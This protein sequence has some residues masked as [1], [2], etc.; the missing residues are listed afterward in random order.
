MKGIRQPARNVCHK[1]QIFTCVWPAVNLAVTL[2]NVSVGVETIS[3][4]QIS[5]KTWVSRHKA[6]QD[7]GSGSH[8]TRTLLTCLG[9]T[10]IKTHYFFYCIYLISQTKDPQVSD[11]TVIHT[12]TVLRP[13]FWD[14]P[15][16]PVQEENFWTL[17]C[18]GRLLEAD[19]LIIR[20]NATPS[21]LTSAHLHHPPI[22]C[23]GRMPFLPPNQ[24]CQSTVI[25]VIQCS[26]KCLL[27]LA[28]ISW[29]NKLSLIRA[30]CGQANNPLLTKRTFNRS[31]YCRWAKGA[32]RMH[33]VSIQLW[34]T[35]QHETAKTTYWSSIQSQDKT[36]VL[37]SSQVRDM[38]NCPDSTAAKC[39]VE[40]KMTTESNIAW[41]SLLQ[42]WV[43]LDNFAPV[44]WQ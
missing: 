7:I 31:W 22:L 10:A 35:G 4:R 5:S 19:T 9:Y 28:S 41:Q 16:E 17:W 20:L 32:L 42:F 2:E 12:T 30:P 27:H 44:Y 18:K 23:T 25:T 40:Q 37:R 29:H 33:R 11:I 26:I 43:H 36:Q 24:E 34:L 15:G 6:S 3:L 21:G 38:K 13:F 14:H 1:F 39:L 8:E